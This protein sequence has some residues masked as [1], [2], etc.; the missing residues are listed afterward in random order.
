[1][2][3]IRFWPNRQAYLFLN[4]W[5]GLC[6]A[7]AAAVAIDGV[8][9]LIFKLNMIAR[10]FNCLKLFQKKNLYFYDIIRLMA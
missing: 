1:M 3:I 6:V 7:V 10:L 8:C 2:F 5:S 9:K 4:I